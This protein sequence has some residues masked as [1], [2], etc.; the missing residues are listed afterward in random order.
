MN[1]RIFIQR[2]VAVLA[3]GVLSACVYGPEPGGGPPPWAPAHG[4]RR[5]HP[6][7]ATL[8]YDAGLGVYVVAGMPGYYYVDDRFYRIVDGGW[9]AA[10]DINGPWHGSNT[11][12]LPPGLA[13][14]QGR[15]GP[16]GHSKHR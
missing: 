6:S 7:G 12:G 9:H 15:G 4:Y 14:K 16:P 1:R 10:V 2:T 11:R 13:K 3:G 5:K 8:V